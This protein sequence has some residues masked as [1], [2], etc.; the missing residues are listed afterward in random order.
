MAGKLK[1]QTAA[2][3]T[4]YGVLDAAHQIWLAGMGAFAR[5]TQEGGK[6][7]YS[8]VEEGQKV[9]AR[10]RDAA[11]SAVSGAVTGVVGKAGDNWDRV[12]KIFEDRVSR[13]LGR[14]GVPTNDDIAALSKR[15]EQ[16]TEAVSKLDSQAAPKKAAAAKPAAAKKASGASDT[17]P[18]S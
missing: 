4:K 7:F 5:T 9:Q 8:L 3:E 1:S 16:L 15:V 10:S 14:L 2:T 13:V 12:E 18:K 17:A 11:G 6:L